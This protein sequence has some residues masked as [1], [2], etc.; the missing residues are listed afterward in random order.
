MSFRMR[1]Y[2]HFKVFPFFLCGPLEL[3][4]EECPSLN[5]RWETVETLRLREECPLSLGRDTV[6]KLGLSRERIW[7]LLNLASLL[8][9]PCHGNLLAWSCC[10]RSAAAAGLHLHELCKLIV[11]GADWH[12]WHFVLS[13]I[14]RGTKAACTP[15]G[16]NCIR[17]GG[18]KLGLKNYD[19]RRLEIFRH[20]TSTYE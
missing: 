6:G 16:E 4:W 18:G 12:A 10:H 19:E 11:A 14:G 5:P 9:C 17:L 15:L 2:A 3:L 13:V 7:Q 8:S 20:E 1:S